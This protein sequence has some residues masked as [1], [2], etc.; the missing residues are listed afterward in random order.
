MIGSASSVQGSGDA[1]LGVLGTVLRFAS[2]KLRL[3]ARH[4]RIVLMDGPKKDQDRFRAD[5]AMLFQ[6]LREGVI[7]PHIQ[8]VL[9]LKDARKAQELLQAGDVAGKVVLKA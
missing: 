2:L 8:V 9:P 4:A 1:R 7:N 6:W 5:M 3:G